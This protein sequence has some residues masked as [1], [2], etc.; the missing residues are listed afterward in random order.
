[1][2]LYDQIIDEV[3]MLAELDILPNHA[4]QE[5]ITKAVSE[6]LHEHIS[7][8]STAARLAEA[9]YNRAKRRVIV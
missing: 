3:E 1:M 2:S 5:Q 6:V 8:N 4:T 7:L 9:T